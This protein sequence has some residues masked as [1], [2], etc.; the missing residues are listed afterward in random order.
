MLR[1]QISD[2]A[3]LARFEADFPES[4]LPALP[5]KRVIVKASAPEELEG[6]TLKAV[7]ELL[8]VHPAVLFAVRQNSGA[9]PVERDGRPVPIW[10]YKF[11]RRPEPMTI[12]DYWG[13]L[14][15]GRPFALECKRASWT[16]PRDEREDRQYAYL[17]MIASIGGVSGFVRSGDEAMA[18]LP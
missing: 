6:A 8:A 13:F 2:P 16:P 17:Q 9:M 4:R 14:K 18:L 11:A 3:Q 1:S 12:V 5:K 15:D 7:G 10:F